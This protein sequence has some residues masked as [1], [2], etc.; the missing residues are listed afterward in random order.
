[1]ALLRP[2]EQLGKCLFIGVDRM[3]STP[4]QTN[5]IDRFGLKSVAG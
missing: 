5:A 2:G 1:L 3:W 4:D